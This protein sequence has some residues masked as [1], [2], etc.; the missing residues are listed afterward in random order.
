MMTGKYLLLALLVGLSA[1]TTAF[2]IGEGLNRLTTKT[3]ENPKY[4]WDIDQPA[5][6]V[7]DTATV[8]AAT[9]ELNSAPKAE[10][11]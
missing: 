9:S 7:P 4:L 5:S 1:C 2:E 8:P 11:K 10:T 3:A 6:A